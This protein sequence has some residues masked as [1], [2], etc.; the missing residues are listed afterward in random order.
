MRNLL[1]RAGRGRVIATAVVIVTS[2][3][4]VGVA[5]MVFF[6][7]TESVSEPGIVLTGTPGSTSSQ[8]SATATPGQA[9]GGA[10]S[11]RY[12]QYGAEAESSAHAEQGH[13]PQPVEP[14]PPVAVDHGSRQPAPAAPNVPAATTRSD[15]AS[16]DVDDDDDDRNPVRIGV[17]DQDN[18][19]DVDD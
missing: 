12:E 3:L 16:P 13:S 15:D 14:D 7:P 11:T 1:R 8:S 4:L 6:S 18:D 9:A 10:S 2:G 19:Y 17:R 5:R